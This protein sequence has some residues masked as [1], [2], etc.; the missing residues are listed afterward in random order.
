MRKHLLW[1]SV[2]AFLTVAS[3]TWAVSITPTLVADTAPN[4]YGSPNWGPWWTQAKADVAAGTFINMRSGAHPGTTY[5][6]PEE[7][8]V[9]STMDLG[10]RLHW[11]YWV[12]GKTISDLQQC[13]FQVN[14]MVDWEGVNYV[15]D[16]NAYDLIVANL[17]G[18][19]P[20]NGWI[21]PSS[22]IEYD[23]DNDG[24]PDGVIGTFG[25]AWWATDDEAPPYNTDPNGNEWWDEVNA[26]DV[27]AL[28]AQ[29]RQYQTHA[30]GYIRWY[31]GQGWEYRLLQLNVVPE[32][33]TVVLW[34]SGFAAPAF[35]LLR[36]RK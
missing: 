5:F 7:E 26:D 11:I 23:K 14:W 27:A 33:G 25:F 36:R 12:P 17:A 34:L 9:Y 10:K 8:I 31:C 3:S 4:V 28:A 15:Y 16:W 20:T 35:A 13:N 21:Q 1:L 18:G 22:W 32:P 24:N 2:L 29:I 6:E 30:T 19:I